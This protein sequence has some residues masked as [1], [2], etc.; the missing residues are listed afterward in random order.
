MVGLDEITG[1]SI[2]GRRIDVHETPIPIGCSNGLLRLLLRPD[3][4]RSRLESLQQVDQLHHERQ[5]VGER[6]G[7]DR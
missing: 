3:Q 2:N 1:Q 6:L 7:V 5:P 4:G